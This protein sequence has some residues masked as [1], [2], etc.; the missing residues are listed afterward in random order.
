MNA[1]VK[2]ALEWPGPRA[3]RRAWRLGLL[4]LCCLALC[5]LRG[6]DTPPY[7][8]EMYLATPKE[9]LNKEIILQVS[10]IKPTR[11][12][13]SAEGFLT[14]E[15]ATAWGY[16]HGGKMLALLHRDELTAALRRYGG[17]PT[18][19]RDSKHT[20]YYKTAPMSGILR[21]AQDGRYYLDIPKGTNQALLDATHP[22]AYAGK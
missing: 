6:D 18:R 13:A 3:R 10:C 2:I 15:V 21:R 14:I 22:P 12:A 8:V 7:S 16:Y 9:W 1:G 11:V 19:V 17:E 5:P 20:P 4:A